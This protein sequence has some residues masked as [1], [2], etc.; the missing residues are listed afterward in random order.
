MGVDTSA[1]VSS[2]SYNNIHGEITANSGE[3][4]LYMNKILFIMTIIILRR[5]ILFTFKLIQW[6]GE[7]NMAANDR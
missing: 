3:K 5:N 4:K 6:S 1:F 2:I 7:V